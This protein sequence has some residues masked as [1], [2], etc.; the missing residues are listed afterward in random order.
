M[1]DLIHI[2]E[3]KRGANLITSRPL[4]FRW[5]DWTTGVALLC[6]RSESVRFEKHRQEA[7]GTPGHQHVAW[8]PNHLKLA[9]GSHFT[10]AGLF[11]HRDNET[12]MRRVYRLAAMMECVTRGTAPVLRTDLLRRLY[13]TIVRERDALGVSWK[14]AVDHYLLP[15][16]PEHG[17]GDRLLARIRTSES[18]QNLFRVIEEETDRQFDLL[19]SHYVIYVPRCFKA[20]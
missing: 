20:L 2:D 9:G 15:L 13:Q 7:R 4:E 1:A 11:R 18:L 16:Y 8:V 6:T 14:G 19:G 10:V 17:G 5:G 12:S 3:W